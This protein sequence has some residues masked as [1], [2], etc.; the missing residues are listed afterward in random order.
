[1]LSRSASPNPGH[2]WF[3]KQ[4][5][6]LI[7]VVYMY[8]KREHRHSDG[9]DGLYDFACFFFNI[10]LHKKAE[11]ALHAKSLFH[12]KNQIFQ[13]H[14]GAILDQCP[15]DFPLPRGPRTSQILSKLSTGTLGCFSNG[16]VSGCSGS[17]KSKTKQRMVVL[18]KG[19]PLSRILGTT[20][21][22]TQLSVADHH[23]GYIHILD[24]SCQDVS[25]KQPILIF[26][27][28]FWGLS[29]TNPV[30][31][32]RS[33]LHGCLRWSSD[34]D[35]T[36]LLY[37][38]ADLSIGIPSLGKAANMVDSA[39]QVGCWG[40]DLRCLVL[41]YRQIQAKVLCFWLLHWIHS[42]KYKY[43][44]RDAVIE[45]MSEILHNLIWKAGFQTINS[46]PHWVSDHQLHQV[47]LPKE[48]LL[49]DA[50][51]DVTDQW[52]GFVTTWDEM[53]CSDMRWYEMRAVS[54]LQ[55]SL[56]R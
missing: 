42:T 28:A 2:G 46:K 48:L 55:M 40:Q 37:H 53:E 10:I 4:Q 22:G 44:F 8:I 17:W 14:F 7:F 49:S 12:A 51:C 20:T 35:D 56:H 18:T 6:F 11:S 34:Q 23:E 26:W 45:L 54:T 38:S 33:W 13:R 39:S 32:P 5:T 21:M 24:S 36:I 50:S 31:K 47:L 41:L 29:P 9:F 43:G 1:M 27:Y 3:D 19:V 25:I 16:R 52:T 15:P 30:T